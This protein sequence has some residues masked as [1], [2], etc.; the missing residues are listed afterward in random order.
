MNQNDMEVIYE[1]LAQAIDRRAPEE[2]ELFLARAC[3]ML[4]REVGDLDR[5]LA[6]IA[7]AE[8]A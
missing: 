1:A 5:A 8:P 4:A 2:P 6:A 7:A 3:L